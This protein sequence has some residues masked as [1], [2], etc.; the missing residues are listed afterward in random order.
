M[1]L[2]AELP[3]IGLILASKTKEEGTLL[4]QGRSIVD[5]LY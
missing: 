5:M 1:L 2:A 4:K 3:G